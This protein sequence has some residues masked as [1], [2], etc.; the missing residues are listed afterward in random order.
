MIYALEVVDTGLEYRTCFW[1]SDPNSISHGNNSVTM[2]FGF[3]DAP[4]GFVYS[5]GST[6]V[7]VSVVDRRFVVD[8]DDEAGLFIVLAED[9]F[10]SITTYSPVSVRFEK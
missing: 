3:D 7:S 9:R 6:K 5:C 2:S 8:I 10:M 1:D 4:K